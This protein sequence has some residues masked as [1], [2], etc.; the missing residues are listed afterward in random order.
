MSLMDVLLKLLTSVDDKNKKSSE[1]QL[2]FLKEYEKNNHSERLVEYWFCQ[3]TQQKFACY[4]DICFMMKTN[5]PSRVLQ[6]AKGINYISRT[7]DFNNNGECFLTTS[8]SKSNRITVFILF[9]IFSL[10]SL[11]ALFMLINKSVTLF[12]VFLSK[13]IAFTDYLYLAG[14]VV[15]LPFMLSF[16][17]I[18]FTEWLAMEKATV[19]YDVYDEECCGETDHCKTNS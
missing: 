1:A 12:Y 13:G 17:F 6:S 5:N 4:R 11:S 7:V 15:L 16:C 8:A 3:M 18:T 19:F 10:S 14:A 9:V 2:E